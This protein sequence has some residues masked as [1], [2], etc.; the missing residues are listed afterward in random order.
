MEKQEPRNTSLPQLARWLSWP[1]DKCKPFFENTCTFKWIFCFHTVESLK[2]S[3]I[4]Y[5]ILP[6][7]IILT[8]AITVVL[9][10][11]CQFFSK[12]RLVQINWA[13]SISYTKQTTISIHAL[14]KMGSD[15]GQFI[16]DPQKVVLHGLLQA[17]AL[18]NAVKSR[19]AVFKCL[20]F[21]DQIAFLRF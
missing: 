1:R 17:L 9:A 13:R 21:W 4:F 8:R 2:V 3:L 10:M 7:C 19:L 11:Q 15:I 14:H 12:L 16:S 20:C 5:P 18:I 6:M